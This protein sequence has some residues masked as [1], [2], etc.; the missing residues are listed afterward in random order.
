MALTQ[1]QPG[2]KSTPTFDFDGGVGGGAALKGVD[3]H[4]HT[5]VISSGFFHTAEHRERERDRENA[6]LT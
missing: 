4:V 6:S 1:T 2:H 3:T 5:G